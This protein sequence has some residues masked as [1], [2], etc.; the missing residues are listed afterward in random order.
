MILLILLKLRQLLGATLMSNKLPTTAKAMVEQTVKMEL[1]FAVIAICGLYFLSLT[2]PVV[3]SNLLVTLSFALIAPIAT[4]AVGMA[5]MRY[6]GQWVRRQMV[7]IYKQVGPLFRDMSIGQMVVIGIAAGVCEEL[8]FRALLQ[9]ALELKLSGV[10][11]LVIA[12]IVFGAMHAMTFL[13]FIMATVMGLILGYAYQVTGDLIGVMAWH[14]VYD[15]IAIYVMARKPQWI[16]LNA[17][18]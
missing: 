5:S 6:S 14:A 8:F 18:D 3:G 1:S 16:G 7:A 17:L 12:S 13:Y 11:A 2:P 4:Y 15:V 9:N 10:W